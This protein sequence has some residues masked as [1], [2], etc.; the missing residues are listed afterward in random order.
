MEPLPV[1]PENIARLV[2]FFDILAAIVF[3][4]S[5]SLVASRKKLDLMAFMWFA[6]ITGV[7]GGTVRESRAAGRIAVPDAAVV[8]RYQGSEDF[9]FMLEKKR[10]PTACSATAR[11]RWCITRSTSST[12]PSCRR[13]RP[14]GS[15]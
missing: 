3:A 13:G 11:R 5:G 9:A 10:G 1:D 4:V 7:G 12:T 8:R 15:R 14:P 6:V 2:Y